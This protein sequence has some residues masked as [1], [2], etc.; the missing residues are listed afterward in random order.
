MQFSGIF[1]KIKTASLIGGLFSAYVFVL[2]SPE[3][4]HIAPYLARK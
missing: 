2:F 4:Y 1:S 3:L